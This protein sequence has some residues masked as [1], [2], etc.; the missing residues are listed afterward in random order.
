MGSKAIIPALIG[1]AAIAAT[2]GLATPAVAGAA[3]ADTLGTAGAAGLLG[4]TGVGAATSAVAPVVAESIPMAATGL[5]EIGMANSFNP[6]TGEALASTAPSAESV[7][8]S[9][10]TK[11]AAEGGMGA[12]NSGAVANGTWD[13]RLANLK[14]MAGKYGTVD[15]TIGAAKLMA[16]MPANT[17]KPPQSSASVKAASQMQQALTAGLLD[18]YGD[19][20]KYLPPKTRFSLLG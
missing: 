20:S 17:N 1:G 18:N 10:L 8:P 16:A 11:S 6:I 7:A 9:L 4:G 13:T 3:G 12:A 19:P 14:D 15:N 2:G 5:P